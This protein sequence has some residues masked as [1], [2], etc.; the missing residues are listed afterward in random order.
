MKITTEKSDHTKCTVCE[1]NQ[2][3]IMKFECKKNSGKLRRRVYICEHCLMVASLALKR[4]RE[5][6][7]NALIEELIK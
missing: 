5:E 1:N 2:N 7:E 6:K 4:K 3:V